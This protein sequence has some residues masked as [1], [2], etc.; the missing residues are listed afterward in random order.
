VTVNTPPPVVTKLA[1]TPEKQTTLVNQVITLT[2]TGG[3]GI[4]AWTGGG[5]PASGQ[6]PAFQ[7]TFATGGTHLATVRSGEQS[8]T[9]K[10]TAVMP[11]P[12]KECDEGCT[13]GY[14][15]QPHHYDSWFGYSPS[16]PFSSVFENAF[17]GKTL[18]EVLA[19]NG[20]G[21]DA[22]GRHAVA[23]LLNATSPGVDFE[24]EAAAVVREFNRVYPDGDY[25]M[26]KNRLAAMNERNCPLR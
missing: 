21:I 14:W 22:L 11:H 13:P 12:E 23:A 9:C 4:Y 19:L 10:I 25:E 17:P 8:A 16:T 6:G 7:T 2:A 24:L 18:A 20:G 26:V 5:S 1:C 15:K 3:T